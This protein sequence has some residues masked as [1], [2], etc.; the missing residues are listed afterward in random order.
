MYM[1]VAC[2]TNSSVLLFAE[3][4]QLYGLHDGNSHTVVVNVHVGAIYSIMEEN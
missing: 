1:Y 4:S 3:S 2:E